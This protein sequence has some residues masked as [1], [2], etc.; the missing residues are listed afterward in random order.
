MN[1][2]LIL[3]QK[4]NR[5]RLSLGSSFALL[6]IL[7]A[8][9]LMKPGQASS[10]WPVSSNPRSA[11]DVFPAAGDTCAAATVISPASL[12]FTEESTTLGAASDIDPGFGSCAQGPG[13]D[14]VY[15]FTPSASDIYAVG[16][17]PVGGSSFDLSL[18]IVTDCAS[19]ASTCVAGANNQ[20]LAKGEVVRV[21]LTAGTRYFIVVD[22]PQ[23]SGS[24]PFHFSLRRGG[25]IND[26]CASPVVIDPGRL[27]FAASATTFG[28]TND[29]NPGEPCLRADQSGSGPDIVYQF[30]SGD[31][32]N[33]DVT[34][35]PAGNFDPSVYIVTNCASLSGC[36]GA[37]FGGNG[38]TET[39]R[40]N[41]TSGITY[42]I[43][44]DG[45]QGDAGDFTITLVPTIPRAPDAPTDLTATA[46]SS[47]RIDLAWHDNSNNEIGFRVER[48]L[49]GSN[50]AEIASLGSNVTAFSD[51]T[52]FASTFFFYRVFAFNN[53]GNSDPSNIAFAQT[54]APPIPVN[55]V[56]VVDPTSI[57]F[58]SVRVSQSDTR[59]I[60]ITN[61][62]QANLIISAISD[63]GGAFV[64]VGKPTLPVTILS[65][66]S[67]ALSVRFAP[68]VIGRVTAS[69]AIQSNDPIA[70][71]VTVNL[72]GT[73]TGGAVPNL[74]ISPGAIDFGTT[75]TPL[76]LDLKN[77]GEADL[78]VSS[79]IRPS[80]PF[81]VSGAIPATLKTGEKVTLT[82]TFSP[83]T[84]GVFTSGL[85]V[86][87]NDPDALL[88][89][90]PLRGTSLTQTLVPRVVGLEFRKNGL[91]FQAANSNVVAGAVL[92]VDGSQTFALELN[93]DI[94]VVGKKVKSTPGNLRVRD[95][96]VSPSTHSVVVRNPN[97]GTSTPVSIS[98]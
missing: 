12:P 21:S 67:I 95:I 63:P 51:T 65:T 87:C 96:F 34:I 9:G 66:Q 90:I 80:A 13:P 44:V 73:G 30:T 77:T 37:D 5:L 36:S 40:R 7:T 52:V 74:E 71:S 78:L 85:T 45:F 97:G 3:V 41:L 26:N 69:F 70:P 1:R 16:A 17:T 25:P 10:N 54:P 75:T 15:S 61:G 20:G 81:S 23:I 72:A 58:G 24:G 18:Y 86:V 48:S 31:S 57:D 76:M 83:T 27:P 6:L 22:S 50:F 2:K 29:F 43:I 92:I 28:A 8:A 84:V 64:I 94:W 82:I 55:P 79:I 91:R 19:P 88:T 42:F 93:G 59:T 14:V 68:N 33:Y 38:Q 56:I 98:V 60:T 49:D 11:Q 89:F 46:V 35:T 39:L 47:T 4:S 62:G 53:F 32:Q